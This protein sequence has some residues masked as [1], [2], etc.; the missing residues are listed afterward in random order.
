MSTSARNHRWMLLL[1]L[2][3]MAMAAV[4]PSLARTWAGVVGGGLPWQV[5]C[6]SP[7]PGG[8]A[9]PTDGPMAAAMD[10]CPYCHLRVD[11]APPP[12]L[13]AAA[14]RRPLAERLL[15]A[16]FL[17]SPRPLFAWHRAQPRAPP[18]AA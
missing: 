12:V 1:L 13:D 6:V 15:P 8:A 3:A 9:Q 18:S 16:L 5:V 2:C 14:V 11:M 17:Q 4:A 10:D 7:Q